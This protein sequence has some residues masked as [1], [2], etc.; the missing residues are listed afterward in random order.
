MKMT[1]FEKVVAIVLIIAA[2]ATVFTVGYNCGSK[3]SKGVMEI[4][5]A[6][7]KTAC[8]Q[9]DRLSDY[10][11]IYEDMQADA[12]DACDSVSLMEFIDSMEKEDAMYKDMPNM[13]I[14]DWTYT[15]KPNEVPLMDINEWAYCY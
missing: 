4:I 11:R 1:A 2:L 13:H 8:N 6:E 3:A 15:G 5:A 10:V 9:R 12:F 14:D 7:Y